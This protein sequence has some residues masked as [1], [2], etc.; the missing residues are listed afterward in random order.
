MGGERSGERR[1][2]PA[3]RVMLDVL[4]VE[5]VELEKKQFRQGGNYATRRALI[6]R[7]G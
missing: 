5:L 6:A 2:L 3:L 4:E 7:G 1:E